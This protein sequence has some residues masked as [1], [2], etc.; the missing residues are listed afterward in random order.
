MRAKFL[1]YV[2]ILKG[3]DKKILVIR[4]VAVLL[5]VRWTIWLWTLY[6]DQLGSVFS[7]GF[8][9]LLLEKVFI[10]VVLNIG[11]WIS[12]TPY[13]LRYYYTTLGLLVPTI[14][15]SPFVMPRGIFVEGSMVVIGVVVF[16]IYR[17]IWLKKSAA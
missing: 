16:A 3:M 12:T 11:L 1:S 17:L 6:A 10:A 4:T 13:G 8:W 14:C 5:M 15:L 9:Y 7:F 2:D